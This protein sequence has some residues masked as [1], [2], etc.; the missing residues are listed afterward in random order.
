VAKYTTVEHAN[1]FGA[2]VNDI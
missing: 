2:D 1:T